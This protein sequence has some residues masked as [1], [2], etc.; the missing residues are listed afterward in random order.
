[1]R[2]CGLRQAVTGFLDKAAKIG[3][4]CDSE[5]RQDRFRLT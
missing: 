4:P 1:V 5:A 3:D 2:S